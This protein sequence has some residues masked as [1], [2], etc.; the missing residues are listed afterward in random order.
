MIAK[1]VAIA[2]FVSSAAAAGISLN[3]KGPSCPIAATS[4]N[5]Y[6]IP[7]DG[8]C[9]ETK[10]GLMMITELWNTGTPDNG[11]SK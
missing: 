9:T 11:V 2:A 4:C 3:H 6:T 10:G 7:V 5:N 1:I 8:C